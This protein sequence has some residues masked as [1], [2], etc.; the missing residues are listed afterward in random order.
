MECI[1]L[2]RAALQKAL[3]TIKRQCEGVPLDCQAELLTSHRKSVQKPIWWCLLSCFLYQNFQRLSL[4][5]YSILL[6]ARRK[7]RFLL[8]WLQH[9]QLCHSKQTGNTTVEHCIGLLLELVQEFW[10]WCSFL[11][12]RLFSAATVI[13]PA[14]VNHPHQV[15]P[16]NH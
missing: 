11:I 4:Q 10:V 5:V 7:L 16:Q 13:L 3:C 2:Q 15:E 9:T 8:S 14:L 12:P 6:N 1:S